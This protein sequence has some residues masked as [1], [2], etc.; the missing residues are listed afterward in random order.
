[1]TDKQLARYAA[2]ILL[3]GHWSEVDISAR[4]T[5]ALGI[6]ELPKWGEKFIRQI[7][8]H[9][10][11]SSL[12]PLENELARVFETPGGP[13]LAG[14]RD[15]IERILRRLERQL[16]TGGR[17]GQQLN[18]LSFDPPAMAPAPNIPFSDALPAIRS[19][20]QLAAW[21]AVSPH[22]LDWF[23]DCHGRERCRPSPQLSHYRYQVIRKSSGKKRLLEV[24]KRRLKEIQ[25]RIL[26]EILEKI[27]P[28]FA[29]HAFRQG[30]STMTCAAPHVG[31]RVVLRIDL[32]NFFPSVRASRVFALFRTI[33]YPERVARLLAG[34]CTN[35]TPLEVLREFDLEGTANSPFALVHLPQGAPTSPA[36]AN[37]C[38]FRLDRRL[39][40]L[41]RKLNLAYSR[42]ADDLIFSGNRQF[43]KGLSKFRVLVCAILLDEGFQI[44]RRETRVMRDASRQEVTGLVVNQHTAL[45]RDDFDLLKATLFNCVRHGPADQNRAGV[46]N[47]R[48]HLH[49]RIAYVRMIQPDRAQ[50]LEALFEKIDWGATSGS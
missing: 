25:R 9:F 23:A 17:S 29:A 43:E 48:A 42:Y 46:A 47:F 18:L 49:G 45:P 15:P 41:A 39:S 35:I 8:V 7:I 32:R 12:P 30:R 13:L 26:H 38:A 50:K 34:L 19:P 2:Q 1:M 40:G 14:R 27:P 37:L 6:A 16:T 24:P 44:R 21:L 36:L 28:H 20:G 33:G 5:R 31:Q 4:L 11:R 3:A 10:S 22:E